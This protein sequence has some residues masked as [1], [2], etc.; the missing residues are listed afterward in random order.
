M[1][2]IESLTDESSVVRAKEAALSLAT[3]LANLSIE[4]SKAA[5]ANFEA[6]DRVLNSLFAIFRMA[7]ARRLFAEGKRLH[8]EAT[9]YLDAAD[10][11]TA[12]A[13]GF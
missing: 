4:R 12:R 1:F 11:L 9:A 3:R 13:R 7:H 2:D 6:S 10:M 5:T 8:G